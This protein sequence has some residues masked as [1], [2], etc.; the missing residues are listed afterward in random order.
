MAAKMKSGR[1]L[2]PRF[3]RGLDA[4]GSRLSDDLRHW[5]GGYLRNQ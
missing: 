4:L 5:V 2:F 1:M 3:E